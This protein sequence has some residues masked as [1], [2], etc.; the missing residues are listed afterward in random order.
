M[1]GLLR[2]SF[3]LNRRIVSLTPGR[4][5]IIS[6]NG[7]ISVIEGNS[8]YVQVLERREIITENMRLR[9]YRRGSEV[10]ISYSLPFLTLKSSLFTSR[11][12]NHII[13]YI[14]L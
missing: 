3:D 4:N 10:K 2:V 13:L 6:F 5:D 7:F 9:F 12:Y 1:E 8:S 14:F 11:L